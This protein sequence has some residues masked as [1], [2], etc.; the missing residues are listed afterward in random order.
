[1]D[2]QI[3]RVMALLKE[4][5][6]DDNTLVMFSSDNGATFDIGGVDTE[7]FN[8]VGGLRGRKQDLY[9]GGIRVPFIASWPNKIPAG[10]TTD[11]IS[12]Q[13][14][15]MAT[16]ADLIGVVPPANDGVSYLPTLLGKSNLQKKRDYIYFE[17]PEKNGQV[18]LRMGDWKGV[19]SNMKKDRNAAWEIYHMRTD[20]KE[21]TDLAAQH[22]ELAERFEAIVKKEHRNAHIREWEFVDPKFPEKE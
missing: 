11:H 16:L 8:S 22:T 18:A 5:N 10:K 13:Y 9:E 15:L 21:T 3:G 20:E 4:L 2:K 1:M 19:K 17:F 6:L 7:F 12:V 14:D